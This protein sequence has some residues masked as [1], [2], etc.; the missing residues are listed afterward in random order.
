[1]PGRLTEIL[2]RLKM[3]RLEILSKKCTRVHIFA[4]GEEKT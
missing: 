3:A 1:M 2:P 4:I